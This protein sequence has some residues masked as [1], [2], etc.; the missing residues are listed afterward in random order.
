MKLNHGPAPL[1]P[2]GSTAPRGPTATRSVPWARISPAPMPPGTRSWPR[3][4]HWNGVAAALGASEYFLA[5]TLDITERVHS[6][7]VVLVV[8]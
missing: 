6:G 7:K 3:A 4:Q 2:D 1:D 5:A 8:P